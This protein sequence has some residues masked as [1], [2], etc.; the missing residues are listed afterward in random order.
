VVGVF[1]SLLLIGVE[2][3]ANWLETVLWS[4][5]PVAFGISG[6]SNLWILVILTV[7][8]VAVGL[9]AWKVPGHAGPDPATVG[10]VEKPLPVFALPSLLLALILM[11][12][13]GV[14][15]GPENPI[16]AIDIGLVFALGTRVLPAVGATAW[17]GLATAGMIGAMFGTPVA[18]ALVLSEL[19][20]QGPP[21][22]LWDR[23]FAPMV[24]AGAG[25]LTSDFLGGGRLSLA[26]SLPPYPG[27]RLPDLVAGALVASAAALLGMGAVYAFRAAHPIFHRIRN[28]L[29]MTTVGGL[30]LGIL[31]IIGG[32]ITLFKGL[33]QMKELTQ[34]MSQYTAAGMGWVA[35]VK[36]G[37]LVIAGTCGFRGGRI[38]PSVFI[39]VALGLTVNLFMP[40]V[41]AAL[42]VSCALLGFLLAITRQGWLS[43]FM[44]AVVAPDPA[45]IPV[46][47]LV[48]LPAWLLVTGRPDM[49][50][51]PAQP[52]PTPALPNTA[53][54]P[55]S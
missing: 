9:V 28:P 16:M 2:E 37:A 33:D 44:A 4:T 49:Q 47:T 27:A 34:D 41:P 8:G 38:F 5:I 12:A 18:A 20:D 48:M 26:I 52:E 50:I 43:L 1:S 6:E 25:A 13:G 19:P 23:I 40:A 21:R 45:L 46:M 30:L 29:L 36:I 39:G 53:A 22:P 32:P 11:L 14:S 24:A 35:L 17:I 3:V 55:A 51:T 31:G 15:L 10:L 42:A 54:A 7:T